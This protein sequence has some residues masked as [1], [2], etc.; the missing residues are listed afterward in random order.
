MKR[1][2][3]SAVLSVTC[4]LPQLKAQENNPGPSSQRDPHSIQL[5]GL[6]IQAMGGTQAWKDIKE[7]EAEGTTT[8]KGGP[9]LPFHW[10]DNWATKGRMER[11]G[12]DTHNEQ[13]HFIADE[14]EQKT[15]Q[16]AGHNLQ[17][18]TFDRVAQLILHMP[19][20]V[21]ELVLNDSS[22]GV[23]PTRSDPKMPAAACVSIYKNRMNIA[24]GGLQAVMCFDQKTG[25]P[26]RGA[27]LL[28]NLAQPGGTIAERVLYKDFQQ[29]SAIVVPKSIEVIN[30]VGIHRFYTFASIRTNLSG[31]NQGGQ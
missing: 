7:S 13:H 31:S 23:E 20:A 19:G 2:L 11:S 9:P 10:K 17:K 22:Y 29:T 25:L 26:E 16:G 1:L 6:A 12:P 21:I 18:P 8:I 14:G 3:L 28:P 24:H 4:L 15:L 5:L 27:V 30:P